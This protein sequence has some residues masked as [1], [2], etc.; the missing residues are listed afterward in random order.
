MSKRKTK[1]FGHQSIVSNNSIAA[2]PEIF[3]ARRTVLKLAFAIRNLENLDK[4]LGII[5]P[6]QRVDGTVSIKDFEQG[7]IGIGIGQM[8]TAEAKEVV[9]AILHCITS[10]CS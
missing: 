3:Q 6:I 9:S 8:G 10:T 7:L 1:R 5:K 4:L 2:T